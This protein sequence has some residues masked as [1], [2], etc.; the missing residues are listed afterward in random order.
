MLPLLDRCNAAQLA[1]PGLSLGLAMHF[2]VPEPRSPI[3]GY[4]SNPSWFGSI[5]RKRLCTE[6]HMILF[7]AG[8]A[9][10]NFENPADLVGQDPF[11]AHPFAEY[12]FV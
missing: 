10:A 7:Y 4:R 1:E 8:P 5:R 3:R 11:P 12:R 9:A 2:V 6:L